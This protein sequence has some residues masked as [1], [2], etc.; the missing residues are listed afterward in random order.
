MQSVPGELNEKRLGVFG[1]FLHEGFCAAGHP[2]DIDGVWIDK[3]ECLFVS[4]VSI[5]FIVSVVSGTTATDV[6]F[7]VMS[8]SVT[9]PLKHLADGHFVG[10]DTF[11]E[12]R[13]KQFL[14]GNCR[15]SFGPMQ[16]RGAFSSL[17]TDAC[18]RADRRWGIRIGETHA[19]F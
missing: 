19:E 1:V 2:E 12:S 14:S 9:S 3:F 17:K 15:C 7:A 5:V 6:P 10:R 18:R 4:G 13:F 11:D 16:L 8:G